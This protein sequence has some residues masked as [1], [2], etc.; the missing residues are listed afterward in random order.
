M[1]ALLKRGAPKVGRAA[2]DTPQSAAGV[3]RTVGIGPAIGV[4]VVHD[5]DGIASGAQPF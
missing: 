3:P 1:A 2:F 4:E 5:G